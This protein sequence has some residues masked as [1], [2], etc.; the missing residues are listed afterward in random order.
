VCQT[1]T[2]L[3]D[4]GLTEVEGNNIR[5][6]HLYGCDGTV[7]GQ[8]GEIIE[9]SQGQSL[10]SLDTHSPHRGEG[11]CQTETIPNSDKKEEFNFKVGDRVKQAQFPNETQEVIEVEGNNIRVQ[12]LY[13]CDWVLAGELELVERG[14]AV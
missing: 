2:I 11:V 5:V 12:H 6:Q 8:E 1:E 7:I 13:G 4:A 14:G 10:T 3:Q 9:T